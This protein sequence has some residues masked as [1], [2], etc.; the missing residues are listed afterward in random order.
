MLLY[1]MLF[2]HAS[3]FTLSLLFAILDLDQPVGNEILPLNLRD[4]VAL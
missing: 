1:M 2:S 4:Y 3:N